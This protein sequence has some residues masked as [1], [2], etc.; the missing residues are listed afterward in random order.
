[1][2]TSIVVRNGSQTL[3]SL[4]KKSNIMERINY[5]YESVSQSGYTFFFQSHI[6][7]LMPAV[8][9]VRLPALAHQITL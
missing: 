9:A 3:T 6:L 7:L 5:L 4:D 1:M 8:N 2:K